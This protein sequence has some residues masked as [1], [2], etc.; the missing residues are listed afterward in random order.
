MVESVG[1]ARWKA[2]DANST[3]AWS[4]RMLHGRSVKPAAFMGHG[5]HSSELRH[6]LEAIKLLLHIA[7]EIV[8]TAK[9][10]R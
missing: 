2:A 10:L 7:K 3:A 6:L 5:P 4:R 1:V 9:K 8:N